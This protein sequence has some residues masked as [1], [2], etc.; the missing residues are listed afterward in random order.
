[1]LVWDPPKRCKKYGRKG[2]EFEK[3]RGKIVKVRQG[4]RRGLGWE[5]KGGGKGEGEE[6]TVQVPGKNR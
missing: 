1:M 6:V 4:M 3:E 5:E 2:E